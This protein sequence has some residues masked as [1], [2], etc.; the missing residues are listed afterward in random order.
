M[1][2]R[3]AAALT[4]EQLV[5]EKGGWVTMTPCFS[6]ANGVTPILGPGKVMQLGEGIFW[7]LD[8]V[9]SD[10]TK[11]FAEKRFD[12]RSRILRKNVSGYFGRCGLVFS[13]AS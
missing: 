6:G 2:Q 9:T 3:T 10:G 8:L 5:R 13:Q 7:P 11:C 4:I 12:V 1:K